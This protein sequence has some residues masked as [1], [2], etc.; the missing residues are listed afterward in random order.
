MA[1]PVPHTKKVKALH[2]IWTFADILSFHGGREKFSAVHFE[3]AEFLTK[4]QSKDV[5]DK[6]RRRLMIV[7][8]G[9]LKS[10]LLILYV[11]WRVYRNPNIRILL[12]TNLK[13]LARSFIRE[14]RQYFED[15]ELQELI[16]NNRPHVD[17]LMIPALDAA[18]RRKRNSKRDYE[19]DDDTNAVDRKIIWNAEALQVVRPGK[20][21]EPTIL[22]TSVGTTV[23]GDHY[24]L[25]ILDDIVD[26]KNSDT[27][28]KREKIYEWTQD[29]DSVLDP[30]HTE[31]F[32]KGRT[33]FVEEIGEEIITTGTRYFGGDF[34]DSILENKEELEFVSYIRNVYKNGVDEGEG[35]TYP[36][37]FNSRVVKLL[38]KRLT[39]RRF[40]AQYLN[41][42][43]PDGE[44]VLKWES[45]KWI[46][47]NQCEVKDR[48]VFIRVPDKIRPIEVRPV[49]ALDPAIS[50]LKTA[51]Y[52]AIAVAGFDNERNFY[53]LDLVVGRFSPSETLTQLF[54]LVD[55]WKLYNLHVDVK[56]LGATFPYVI[57][58]A[59]QRDKRKPLVVY[60]YKPQ[61]VKE[62]RI[63]DML[64][65]YW[66][67]DKVYALTPLKQIQEFKSEVSLF[68]LAAHDDA[69]D[70]L[71]IV[72]EV[73]NPTRQANK[74]LGKR[75][76]PKR[77][78][79]K[80]YG[81]TR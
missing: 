76:P 52:T 3:M 23:T 14:L 56:G 65:P 28:G 48:R 16:W 46:E 62:D 5:Q 71:A 75:Q 30:L 18:G 13:R 34:Y 53:I 49:L 58:Q 60:D 27:P 79:N 43:I 80:I 31:S 33:K 35:F 72:A 12:S 19:E 20:F 1:N 17:G 29:L 50:Q 70:V 64:E 15:A 67:N 81:G 36:E 26:F 9:H 40:A 6:D 8:R 7:A 59:V 2:D 10:T 66:K 38:Q 4:A 42:I 69:L 55:K 21:K 37:K 63:S 11:L 68:P 41:A 74:Q 47:E 73:A 77:I 24:D 61:G 44:Q 57:K 45:I 54:A 39:T 32:V 25:V 22:A 78:R 51:D